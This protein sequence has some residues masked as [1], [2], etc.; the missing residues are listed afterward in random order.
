MTQ[1]ERIS[2]EERRRVL[3]EL[4]RTYVDRAVASNEGRYGPLQDREDVIQQAVL[5]VIE[6][7]D[8]MYARQLVSP[9]GVDHGVTD[10]F[11]AMRKDLRKRALSAI[12]SLRY[13]RRKAQQTVAPDQV[14]AKEYR[15]LMEE[16]MDLAAVMDER[17]TDRRKGMLKA[18]L[19][20]MT[21]AEIAEAHGVSLS[22]VHD[23]LNK[24]VEFVRGV[25]DGRVDRNKRYS[26]DPRRAPPGCSHGYRLQEWVRLNIFGLPSDKSGGL[27]EHVLACSFCQYNEELA[28][29]SAECLVLED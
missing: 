10:T 5:W 14:P 1:P 3:A 6:S 24:V 11:E 2:R 25:L 29:G 23:E 20:N 28:V 9:G 13:Q 7:Y 4:A 8:T 15:N 18:R 16:Q 27:R 12:N 22:T 19:D 17:L 21:F 26:I